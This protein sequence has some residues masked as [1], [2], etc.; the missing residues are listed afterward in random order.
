MAPWGAHRHLR[1][2]RCPLDDPRTAQALGG[3]GAVP[4]TGRHREGGTEA[5]ACGAWAIEGVVASY[6]LINIR[7]F[8]VY[9]DLLC[10]YISW[11]IYIYLYNYIYCLNECNHDVGNQSQNWET[12]I[13]KVN[14]EVF[15]IIQADLN[16]AFPYS[17]P[18]NEK[19]LG[20]L[21][22]NG[23]IWR[24]KP[25]DLTILKQLD[26]AWVLNG[27]Y[28][29]I[30]IYL[31]VSIPAL[32]ADSWY[33]SSIHNSW[34]T[35]RSRC[36]LLWQITDLVD[37][38]TLHYAS[39]CMMIS[40][41]SKLSSCALSHIYTPW[42]IGPWIYHDTW[43]IMICRAVCTVWLCSATTVSIHILQSPAGPSHP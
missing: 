31:K 10:V 32:Q 37:L 33:K 43:Y 21:A 34:A 27:I 13:K 4:G 7:L 36:N 5:G 22:E 15:R 20:H 24:M 3:L 8:Y 29:Y 6:Q 42:A 11:Y 25:K 17:V 35:E 23:W 1:G 12:K 41:I 30:Y 14:D 18:R 28:I 16:E 9:Y 38:T 26:P 2:L 19:F 40:I 39:V